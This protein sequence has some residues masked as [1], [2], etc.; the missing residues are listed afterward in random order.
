MARRQP[1]GPR[2]LLPR[3]WSTISQN[4]VL[5][6]TSFGGPPVHFKIVSFIFI[7]LTKSLPNR[8]YTD[9]VHIVPRQV[10]EETP[11]DRRAGGTNIIDIMAHSSVYAK[12]RAVPGAF[13]CMSGILWSWEYENALLHQFDS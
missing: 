8:N 1:E 12:R 9:R 13:Q 5:G 2:G 4:Y 3:L 11:M 6:F 7:A 10:C